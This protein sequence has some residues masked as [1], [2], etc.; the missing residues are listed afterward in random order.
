MKGNRLM[1]FDSYY[2]RPCYLTIMF[3]YVFIA[4]LAG[5]LQC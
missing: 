1:V 4:M 5:E 3:V 2:L